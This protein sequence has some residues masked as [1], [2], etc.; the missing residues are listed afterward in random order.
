MNYKL[1]LRMLGRTLLLETACL[2]LPLLVA[3]FYREDPMPFVFSILLLAAISLPLA[4]IKTKT[5]I[6]DQEGFVI[7]AAI[8]VLFCVFGALPFYFSG[9]FNGYIDSFFEIT[10]GFTTTGASI[11]TQIEPLPRGILFWRSFSSWLGGMGV[12]IFTLAFLPGKG[13]R[14]HN[15]V[16]AESPGPV[17]SKLVPKTAK[18]SKILYTFYIS[19]TVLEIL[20]LKLAGMSWY[21]SIVHSFATIC[22]GGFSPKNLSIGAYP[23]PAIE[24]I[25]TVFMLLSSINFAIYFLLITKRI[26]SVLRSD[27]LRYFLLIVLVAVSLITV[28]LLYLPGALDHYGPGETLRHVIFQ[29][30]SIITTT[31]F[32]TV[33]FNLWPEFSRILLVILMVIGGCAGSTAG[34]IK[35]SRFLLLTRC[36]QRDLRKISHPRAVKVV[37]LDGNALD[38]STL[39]RVSTFFAC[40]AFI[41]AITCL[42]ISLDNFSF[43]TTVTAVF[44]CVSNVGPGLDMVGPLGNYAAFSG[45]SKMA[46]SLCM[47]VGRLEI[48]PILIILAPSTWKRA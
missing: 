41:F 45:L 13:E 23:S 20:S 18:S 29:V 5:Q 2:L 1:I 14:T 17:K 15:L 28:N 25:I 3:L 39:E 8:W 37:K 43:T 21:E 7:V 34:G 46:L 22:T 31:G 44:A 6:L 11:L 10:S 32:S 4:F 35:V 9:Y 38:E 42:V 24:I 36:I 19:L 33:D 47:L 16:R 30:A 27:E 48:F 40:Y 12:L 26:S